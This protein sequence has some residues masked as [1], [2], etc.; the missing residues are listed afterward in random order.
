M[1]KKISISFVS[2]KLKNELLKLRKGDYFDKQ[3]YGF[4]T[5]AFKDIQK[6][7][8]CCVK[9]PKKLWPKDYAKYI[10]TNLWKYDLPNGYRL[11]FTLEKDELLIIA[12]ILEWFSHKQYERRFKY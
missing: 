2:K 1:I 4:I 5:R 12:I 3:L 10:I 7:I 9:I 8:S 6:D 11:I